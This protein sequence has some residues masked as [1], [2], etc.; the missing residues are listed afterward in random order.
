[1]E[2]LDYIAH[3]PIVNQEFLKTTVLFIFKS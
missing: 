1:M 2:L 3:P